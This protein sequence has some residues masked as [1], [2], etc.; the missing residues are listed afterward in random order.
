MNKK[1]CF[2][3]NQQKWN[4]I[5]KK[6][7]P[8]WSHSLF[9][10]PFLIILILVLNNLRHQESQQSMITMSIPLGKIFAHVSY[11]ISS[12]SMMCNQH[13][14]TLKIIINESIATTPNQFSRHFPFFNDVFVNFLFCFFTFRK[15]FCL[16][17]HSWQ[18]SISFAFYFLQPLNGLFTMWLI[19]GWKW[20]FYL[21]LLHTQWLA[22]S[23]CL[24]GT[25]CAP[26]WNHSLTPPWYLVVWMEACQQSSVPLLCFY[27]WWLSLSPKK[28]SN[29][30]SFPGEQGTNYIYD[31]SVLLLVL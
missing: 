16:L 25:D 29:A 13:Y 26:S 15:L 21:S 31:K 27:F 11:L 6:T 17:Q 30:D 4:K 24:R 5:N 12:K 28:T 20:G 10:L 2:Q 23:V 3:Q 22:C 8:G 1:N 19:V 14:M 7:G 9:C 18:Q